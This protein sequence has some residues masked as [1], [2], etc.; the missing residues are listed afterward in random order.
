MRVEIT[1]MPMKKPQTNEVTR[2]RSTPISPKFL[3][4]IMDMKPCFNRIDPYPAV[5]GT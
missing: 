5:S 4:E 3:M 1:S 2:I